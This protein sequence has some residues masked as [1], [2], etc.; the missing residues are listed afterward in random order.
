MID[1]VLAESAALQIEPLAQANPTR[2]PSVSAP[3]FTNTPPL[4]AALSASTLSPGTLSPDTLSSGT[5]AGDY[6][7]IYLKYR[8]WV[9]GALILIMGQSLAIC[10]LWQGLRQQERTEKHLRVFH[11]ALEQSP[12]A[13]VVVNSDFEVEFV[14]RQYCQES[15][16][17][18]SQTVGQ[19]LFGMQGFPFSRNEC[20]SRLS[21]IHGDDCWRVEA[22][23]HG[24]DGSLRHHRFM[25]SAARRSEGDVT[26]YVVLRENI[27]AQKRAEAQLMFQANYDLL[28][29]LPNR[30]LLTT[31][32]RQAIEQADRLQMRFAVL[33]LDLD[34][35]KQINDHYGHNLGDQFLV[36]VAERITEAVE[37]SG[38]VARMGGDEF[39][40][41]MPLVEAVSPGGGSR[42]V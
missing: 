26:H 36:Q 27:D 3:I 2:L 40:V 25:L 5:F 34:G 22:L 24:Q 38:F 28:T 7:N 12:V 9:W 37:G 14:N 21:G 32:I 19:S 16:L 10:L 1:N 39:V 41:L 23:C 20:I 15:R 6:N 42:S 17:S 4:N 31:R 8:H 13:A 29:E 18:L 33:F 30:T 11:T 35:Y